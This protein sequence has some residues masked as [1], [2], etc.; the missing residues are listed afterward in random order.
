MCYWC[1]NQSHTYQIEV[2]GGFLWSPKTGADGVR[3]YFHSV[4]PAKIIQRIGATLLLGELFAGLSIER[5]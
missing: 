3:N 5:G 1:V 2:P 4:P